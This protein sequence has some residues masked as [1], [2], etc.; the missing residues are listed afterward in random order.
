MPLITE[1]PPHVHFGAV[2]FRRSNP[3]RGDWER[4]YAVAAEDGHTLFRHWLPWGAIEVAPGEYD[5][6]DYDRHLDLAAKH[7]IRT[8]L[9]EIIHDVPEWLYH[10]YPH[11]RREMADGRRRRSEMHIS[12]AT[13]GH[14]AMCLDNP[15]V[16][17]AAGAFLRTLAKRYRGH[18]A[19]YAY[20]VWNEC[21]FYRPELICYCEATQGRFREWLKGKYG[22][23][24]NVAKAW[25][26]YSYT[27]WD[28]I[29][30]PRQIKPY[31]DVMDAIAFQMDNAIRQLDW[32]VAQIRSQDPDVIVAAHGNARTHKDAAPACGDDWRAGERVDLFGYTYWYGND[33]DPVFCGRHGPLSLARAPILA[34]R[35]DR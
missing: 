17:D 6:S 34:R 5:L 30:L 9:A 22:T 23:P 1:N 25:L 32:R 18:P 11:A 27:D 15:E 8:V 10:R 20:D 19:L 21:T 26:R 35:G 31:P 28:Q 3:P 16:A 7:G 29:E 14:N 33:C 13:G 24:Q 4:D 2:Y 12:C